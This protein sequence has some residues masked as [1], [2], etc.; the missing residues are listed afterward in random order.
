MPEPKLYEYHVV[1][2]IGEIPVGEGRPFEIGEK[3]VAVFNVDGEYRAIDDMCPHMGASLSA[4][5]LQDGIVACPWHAWRFDTRDG[6]WCDNRRVKIGAYPV[7]VV[8]EEISVGLPR[9][10]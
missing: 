9:T 3:I 6:T 8:G 1:A 10:D 4:G 5:H 2:R 7:R